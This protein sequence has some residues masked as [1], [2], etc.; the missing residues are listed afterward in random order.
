M[1]IQQIEDVI[2]KASQEDQI[3]LE[4]EEY[5]KENPSLFEAFAKEKYE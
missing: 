2:R 5:R 3:I 1:E 4:I